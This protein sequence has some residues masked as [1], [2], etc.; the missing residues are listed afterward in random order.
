MPKRC[1]NCKSEEHLIEDCPTLPVE[2]RRPK[3]LGA[4]HSSAEAADDEGDGGTIASQKGQQR[5]G[6]VKK[7]NS[8]TNRRTIGAGGHK[9]SNKNGN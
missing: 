4:D 3:G 6:K 9:I 5:S 7:Q 1:H 2:K 8:S